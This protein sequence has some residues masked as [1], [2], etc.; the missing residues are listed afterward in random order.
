MNTGKSK[1]RQASTSVQTLGA[2]LFAL[3]CTLPVEDGIRAYN[4]ARVQAGTLEPDVMEQN[5]QEG[6]LSWD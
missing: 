5:F 2:A 1:W 6:L 4:A 3:L